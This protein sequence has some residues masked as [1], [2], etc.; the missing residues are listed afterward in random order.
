M[1]ALGYKWPGICIRPMWSGEWRNDFT[2]DELEAVDA[3]GVQELADWAHSASR[4][5][6]P[7]L[8]LKR[9]WETGDMSSLEGHAGLIRLWVRCCY[10]QYSSIPHS[11]DDDGILWSILIDDALR[12]L[13]SEYQRNSFPAPS[14]LHDSV[15]PSQEKPD[16]PRPGYVYVIKDNR[17]G[18]IKIGR[19]DSW[20]RRQKELRVDEVNITMLNV[21]WVADSFATESRLHERYRS[22]RLPQSEWFNLDHVPVV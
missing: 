22:Y 20:L 19:T 14:G 8:P 6:G 1:D 15:I 9:A 7:S 10:L 3:Y 17:S 4:R 13:R 2:D 16:A 11:D 12:E 21:R 5:L 18:L